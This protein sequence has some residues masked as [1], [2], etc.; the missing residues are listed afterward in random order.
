MLL[1]DLLDYLS[2][3]GGVG[4]SGTDLFAAR[5]PETPDDAVTLYETQGK[6]PEHTMGTTPGLPALE[7]PRVQVVARGSGYVT[8]RQKM[9]DVMVALDGLRNR[10]INGVQYHYIQALQSPFDLGVD[11]LNRPLIV[12]NFE[13]QKAASTS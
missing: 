1:D 13:V 12:C 6:E 4:T 5:R 2:S 7:R 10:T 8:A 9:R 3:D 11:E